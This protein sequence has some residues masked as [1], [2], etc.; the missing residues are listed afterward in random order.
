[1]KS[2][3]II[4]GYGGF[5]ARLS[6]R[7]AAAGHHVL[8]AGRTYARA[9]AFCAGIA[10]CEP[11]E[12]DR[13]NGIGLVLARLRPALVI[14][15]SGPFQSSDYMVAE[16]CI[17][18]HIPYLD[19]ADARAFVVGISRLDKA[20]QLAGIPVI[21]GASSMSGLSGAVLRRLAEDMTQVDAVEMAISASNRSSAGPSVAAAILSYV[22]KPL[23]LWRGKRWMTS[24]GWQEM[25]RSDFVLPDGDG[26]KRRWIAV[27]DVP[28]HDIAPDMLPGRPAV[29]FRAGT[30]LGFQM[31]GLWLASWPVRWGWIGSLDRAR[32]WLLPLYRATLGWGSD[33]SAMNVTIVGRSGTRRLERQ[34]TLVASHGDGRDIPT[35][36]AALLAEDMLADRVAPGAR[37]AW[38]ELD[39]DRFEPLF[40]ILAVR[41]DTSERELPSPLYARLMGPR[42]AALPAMVRAIHD[43]AADGGAEGEGV[44]ARGRGPLVRLIAAIM[45]FPPSGSYPLHVAFAE[46]DG[47]ETWTRDFGGHCFSSRMRAHR[48]RLV[49]RF[50]PIR[51]AFDLPS[52]ESGLR[53]ELHSW[54]IFG[55]PLPVALAPRIVAREWQEEDRFRF[56]VDVAMP[57]LGRV[58]RYSGWLQPVGEI[59]GG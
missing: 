22:G 55:I 54:T 19:L 2:V 21:S 1:V 9:E 52:D 38:G 53:M 56:E 14:D 48:G 41:H 31:I 50:G 32:R 6:K 25:R 15:A 47:A 44:V 24:N 59:G 3:L 5:G 45:R 37:H 18:M 27:A 4:G 58:V 57:L 46:K 35:L 40:A 49:E 23:R 13:E 26:L 39:L 42:F 29:T 16:A 10:N 7:L 33:R 12:A 20:A 28:D 51:F 8:V 30:E 17:A 36:A 34:W 43:V 11:V